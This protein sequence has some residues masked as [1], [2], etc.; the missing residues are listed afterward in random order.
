MRVAKLREGATIPTRKHPDD[1][2]WDLYAFGGHTVKSHSFKT[3]PAGVTI[4]IP[5]NVVGLI[6]P[7]G[8]SNYLIGAGVVD[9]GY[10]GEIMVKVFNVYKMPVH[11][12]HGQAFAQIV[13]LPLYDAGSELNEVSLDDIHQVKTLRSATGGILKGVASTDLINNEGSYRYWD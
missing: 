13:F 2:G 5:K 11:I 12:Q 7:K 10:Q 6:K 1:A 3:I 8:G 9:A 4:E